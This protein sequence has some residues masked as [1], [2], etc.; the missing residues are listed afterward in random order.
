MSATRVRW[1]GWWYV[2]E[3]RVR[4][5]RSYWLTDLLTT[6]GSPLLYLFGLGAGLGVLVDRSQGAAGVEGVPYLLFVSPALVLSAVLAHASEDNTWGLYGGFKWDRSFVAQSATPLTPRQMALGFQ[7]GALI[8]SLVV[9]AGYVLVLALFGVVEW[10]RAVAVLP[11]AALLAL[12]VGFGVAA[13]VARQRE[14]HGQLSFVER[15]V[16]NPLALFSGTFYPLSVLPGYLQW[17]GWVSPLWHACELGRLV[18]YGSPI[19][20]WMVLVHVGYLL[21]VA[22]VAGWLTARAFVGRLGQ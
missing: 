22:A 8:R 10:W 21:L 20:G 15:F 2:A 6:L 19:G 3:Q 13:W 9:A 1:L 11:V 12:S 17:I 16:V 14:E 4:Q 5:M 18:M 7:V